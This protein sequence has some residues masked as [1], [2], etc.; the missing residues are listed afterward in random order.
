[1]K[2][3]TLKTASLLAAS[4]LLTSPAMAELLDVEK[5]ELKFGFIK[6]TDMAPLAVAYEKGY[7]E[8]EGLF[9]TLEAQ[10]NWKVLLDGVISG[11]LDGAHMLAGQPLAA[12]I[13]Y[14]T[15]AHII[16]PFSMDLNG[17]GITVSNEIW[18]EMKQHIPHDDAGKP[19]HPISASALKP[20]VEAYAEEGKPFNMGMVFPVSTHNYEL[21]YWLAAGGLE[22]GFYSP[23]DVSGQI[24][25]DVLLSVTPPP[26]MPATMEAGTIYGYC[27]GEPWNQ[28]AVFKGIGVPVITDYEL[29]KNNPEKVFGLSAEFQQ[30]NPQTTLA[31]TKALIRAAMWLDENDN[32]NRPEA[33]EILSRSEYVGADYDVIANSMTGTFE[34]E[35]GDK[36]DVPDFNVFFRYNATYP[37]YSDAV[38]YLTQMR[39]W[40]QIAEAKPDSWYDE[41][42]KSVY[43]PE[44]YLEAAKM[45]VEEGLA[46]EADFPWDS[47]GYKAATPAADIIDGIPYDGRTPNA[48]LD[49]LPIGLKGEQKVVGS[50]IQG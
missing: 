2:R 40:G 36:R 23:E 25:A 39:R 44:I 47:D 17:N 20:V 26:Q 46:D 38:W 43:K 49:S 29:W 42:A 31:I 30:E 10:A 5:D 37:Y 24:G 8:D 32:A 22:P 35:K 1:M 34:Y 41:I 27:V 45:L 9:V 11:T 50:D 16:T 15:E 6:L 7:F 18:A 14:G 19:I 12:T 3:L 48:Y 13:G 4:T 28:Q 21:R 33:V